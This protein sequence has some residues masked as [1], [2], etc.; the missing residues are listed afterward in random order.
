MLLVRNCQYG[1]DRL[2]TEKGWRRT[3][4]GLVENCRAKRRHVAIWEAMIMVRS[5]GRE[6]EDA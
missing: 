6:S 3:F 5:D 2:L 1:L 4:W